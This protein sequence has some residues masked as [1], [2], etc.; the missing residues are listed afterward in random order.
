M[1]HQPA[2]N[3]CQRSYTAPG[4]RLFLRRRNFFFGRI[5]NPH[6]RTAYLRAVKR[7]LGWAE[8]RGLELVKIAPK[9]VGL[10][11]DGLRKKNLS[12]ATP[13]QTPPQLSATRISF[14][15]SAA[16]KLHE[17]SIRRPLAKTIAKPLADGASSIATCTSLGGLFRCAR[18]Q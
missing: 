11:F 5:R 10:Y 8:T 4:R 12:V 7:F 1:C 14:S 3:S 18:R 9:D 6:T 17:L 2:I 16:L 15:R 13:D